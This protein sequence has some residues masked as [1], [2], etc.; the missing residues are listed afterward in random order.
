MATVHAGYMGILSAGG[1]YIRFTDANISAKQGIEIPDL[2]MGDWDHDAAAYGKIEVNGSINGLVENDFGTTVWD[3]GWTRTAPCG[4]LSKKNVTL[5]YYCEDSGKSV[6]FTDMYVNSIGVSCSAGDIA[7]WTL[8]VIAK[9]A[10]TFGN[11]LGSAPKKTST[12]LVT[13]DAVT[14]NITAADG[15]SASIKKYQNFELTCT[16]NV[17]AI[18]AMKD[19]AGDLFPVEVV[20]GIRTITGSLTGYDIDATLGAGK[21]NY[22]AWTAG[23]DCTLTVGGIWGVTAKAFKVRFHRIEPSATSGV[24][25][26]SIGFTGVSSQT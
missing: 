14:L 2:V 3:W 24:I 26:S 18:Y 1:T 25:T 8:D 11:G 15:I 9:T 23:S 5:Y 19:S 6:A 12:K 22:S 7:N 10:G 4:T 21:N 17:E 20:P 16:N 13:W